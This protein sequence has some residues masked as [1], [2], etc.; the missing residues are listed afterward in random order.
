VSYEDATIQPGRS[1]EYALG[2]PQNG[3]EKL[4]GQVWVDVP[5]ETQL[6]LDPIVPNPSQGRFTVSFALPSRSPATL[7]LV[8]VSGR[9]LQSRQ[10]TGAGG[11][12]HEITLGGEVALKPGIYWVRLEQAGRAFARKVVVRN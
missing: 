8:D 10:V 9:C 11:D 12:R 7:E 5:L 1:Y 6:A 3:A 2:L 4:F